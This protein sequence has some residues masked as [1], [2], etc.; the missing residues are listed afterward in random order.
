MSEQRHP[1]SDDEDVIVWIPCV[2]KRK[3]LQSPFMSSMPIL[4]PSIPQPSPQP[5]PI[6]VM[7]DEPPPAHPPASTP[8]SQ[9][10][11]KQRTGP[12]STKQLKCVE[13]IAREQGMNIPDVCRITGVKVLDQ[14]SNAQADAFIKKYRLGE[15]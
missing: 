12:A 3:H 2:V 13:Y 6:T 8:S 1:S 15:Q 7:P 5:E 10:E 14:M 9:K 4:P 11:N